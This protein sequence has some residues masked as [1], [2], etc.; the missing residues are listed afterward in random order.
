MGEGVFAGS[1]FNMV[2]FSSGLA[3]GYCIWGRGPY[4]LWELHI[5]I[6]ESFDLSVAFCLYYFATSLVKENFTALFAQ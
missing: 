6:S 2:A 4:L 1:F 3:F 5:V